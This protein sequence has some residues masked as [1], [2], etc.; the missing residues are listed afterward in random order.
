MTYE[1][2]IER[3]IDSSPELVFDTM[4]D[5]EAQPEIFA[6]EVPGWDLWECRIDPRVGGEWTF[7]FGRKDRTG[8]PDRSSS[9]FLEVDRP[10]RLA[11]RA[12]MFVGEWGRAVEFTETIT[13][14][15]RDGKTLV[16]IE[17]TDLESEEVRDAFAIGLP[18]YLEAVDRVVATRIT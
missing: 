3:L 18:G 13:F 6:E 14:E 1:L 5:P 7:V 10:R 4:V 8:E 9:V 17:L 2:K 16:T 12:S 15:D 11:Y